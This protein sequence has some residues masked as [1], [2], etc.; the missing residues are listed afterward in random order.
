V[1]CKRRFPASPLFWLH[2]P[3]NAVVLMNL[4]QLKLSQLDRIDYDHSENF[5]L[6]VV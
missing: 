3:S 2:W 1:S 5:E 4:L 6:G